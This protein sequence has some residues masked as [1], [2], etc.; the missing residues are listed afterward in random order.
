MVI[1]RKIR[2]NNNHYFLGIELKY[3]DQGKIVRFDNGYFDFGDLSLMIEYVENN[4]DKSLVYDSNVI[5]MN[6][7][8]YLYDYFPF[9]NYIK[10]I[11]YDKRDNTIR[12]IGIIKRQ[13][14]LAYIKNKNIEIN[15]WDKTKC[16]C[17]LLYK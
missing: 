11:S 14:I 15:R 17:P 7:V 8:I 12:Q 2:I 13:E 16:I 9:I 1:E 6:D 4:Y 3:D 5:Y 10:D